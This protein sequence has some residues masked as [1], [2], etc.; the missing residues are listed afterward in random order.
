ML[1]ASAPPTAAI[2]AR[3]DTTERPARSAS[4]R[5]GHVEAI[6]GLSCMMVVLFHAIGNDEAHGVHAA[7][8]SVLWQVQHLLDLIDMPLFAFVSGRV[9]GIP[10]ADGLR[11]AAAYAR[12]A[13][14]LVVPFLAV[15]TLYLVVIRVTG[16]GVT[17]SPWDAFTRPFEHLW[18]LQASLCLMTVAAIGSWLFRGRPMVFAVAILAIATIAYLTLPSSETNYLSWRNAVSLAPFYFL[19]HLIKVSARRG[20][21]TFEGRADRFDVA[22]FG[23]ILIFGLLLLWAW[24]QPWQPTRA[25]FRA[26][27]VIGLALVLLLTVLAPRS[28]VLEA[29]AKRSYTIYL[30][31]VFVMSPTRMAFL[32]IWPTAPVSVLLVLSVAAGI[33]LPW[34]L[35]AMFSRH[36]I[37][38]L[39]F[40]GVTPAPRTARWETAGA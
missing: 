39:L 18:Y 20:Q 14:R 3:A 32:K 21:I 4:D 33:G 16:H 8:G 40:Q 9:F 7:T 12:K 10:T 27:L 23:T 15:T 6:R 2:A 35:H 38:A 31:H 25:S 37:T 28:V 30:F 22:L 13:I 11:F 26:I 24:G 34:M 19:G 1:S 29:L 36:R 5:M 17:T